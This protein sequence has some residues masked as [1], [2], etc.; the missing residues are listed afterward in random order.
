MDGGGGPGLDTS[1]PLVNEQ[2][3][4]A[5]YKPPHQTRSKKNTKTIRPAFPQ[6]SK[7]HFPHA[8]PMRSKG[9]ELRHL[10]A[11]VVTGLEVLAAS[12]A[13]ARRRSSTTHVPAFEV[14]MCFS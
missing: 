3:K 11:G 12:Q 4:L 2:P 5:L 7:R 10:A 14:D 9:L 6:L 13:N 1:Q 8:E